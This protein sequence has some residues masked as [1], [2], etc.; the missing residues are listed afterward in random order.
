MT[1]ARAPHD[2]PDNRKRQKKRPGH[3]AAADDAFA[4]SPSAGAGAFRRHIFRVSH[5][6]HAAHRADAVMTAARCAVLHRRTHTSTT[7]ER[8][9]EQVRHRSYLT[10][11]RR[12][13]YS[14]RRRR[15]AFR[16]PDLKMQAPCPCL[17]ERREAAGAAPRGADHAAMFATFMRDIGARFF[18]ICR[19]CRHQCHLMR[20]SALAP[21]CLLRPLKNPR[22]RRAHDS[23][24]DRPS[25]D[26]LC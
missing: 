6:C 19:S 22:R 1:S 26:V 3:M 24:P 23:R 14:A 20:E 8:T 9:I 17:L 13:R 5:Y 10:R 25:C 12:G 4:F 11:R 7:V 15:S 2:R 16:R 18:D 21:R